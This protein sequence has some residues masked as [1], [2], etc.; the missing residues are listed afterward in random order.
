ME[1][2]CAWINRA[3]GGTRMTV[4]NRIEPMSFGRVAGPLPSLAIR[5]ANRQDLPLLKATPDGPLGEG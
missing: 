2:T 5:Q 4:R 1:T 3:D